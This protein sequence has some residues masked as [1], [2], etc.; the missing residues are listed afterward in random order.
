MRK[1]YLGLPPQENWQINKKDFMKAFMGD[2]IIV[3]VKI[4]LDR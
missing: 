3:L 1:P 2:L 4:V